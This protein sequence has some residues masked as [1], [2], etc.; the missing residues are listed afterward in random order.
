MSHMYPINLFVALGSLFYKKKH[1][2][3]FWGVPPSFTA[4][5][6]REKAYL[7]FLHLMEIIIPKIRYNINL[8]P[9]EFIKKRNKIKKS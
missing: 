2:A 4:N 8:V 7:K 6:V 5:N 1:I 3:C 9:N